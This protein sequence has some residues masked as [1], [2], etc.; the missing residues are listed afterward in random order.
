[1]TRAGS[2]G[3][4]RT[5]V[6][7]IRLMTNRVTTEMAARWTRNSSNSVPGRALDPDQPVGHGLVALEVLR[8]RDDVVLVVEVDDV[9]SREGELLDRVAVERGPLRV[10][11]HLARSVEQREVS[12]HA[13]RAAL[14]RDA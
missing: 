1:M 3:I 6:K 7:T 4:M 2:P 5:P 10:I 9:A 12:D 11:A 14:Y 8:I 13:Q